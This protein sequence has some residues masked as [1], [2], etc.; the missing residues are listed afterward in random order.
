MTA[1]FKVDLIGCALLGW[2]ILNNGGIG[3]DRWDC[4]LC[5]WSGLD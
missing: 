3:F 4:G 1:T 2:K 5:C